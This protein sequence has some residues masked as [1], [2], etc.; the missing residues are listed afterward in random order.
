MVRVEIN[1]LEELKNVLED[2]CQGKYKEGIRELL[3]IIKE[4]KNKLPNTN[5]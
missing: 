3:T 2:M 1:E 5:T 4:I